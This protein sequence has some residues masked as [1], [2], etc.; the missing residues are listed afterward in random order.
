MLDTLKDLVD[1]FLWDCLQ[2][3]IQFQARD[4][5]CWQLARVSFGK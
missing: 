4:T 3:E 2:A 1:F 5:L